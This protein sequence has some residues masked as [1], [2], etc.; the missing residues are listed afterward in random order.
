MPSDLVLGDLIGNDPIKPFELP[1]RCCLEYNLYALPSGRISGEVIGP[2]GKPLRLAVVYLYSASR[3]K[4]RKQGSYSLQGQSRSFAQ[5]KPFEFYHLPGDDYVLVFNPKN[6]E[7]PDAPFPTTFYPHSPSVEGAQVIHLAD[8]QQLSGTDIQVSDALPT[9]RITLRLVWDDRRR[10]DFYPPQVVVNA[11]T[12]ENPFP[13]ETGRDT[14]TLSLLLSS[15]YTIHAEA[16][17]RIGAT[18]KAETSAET[19]DGNDLS[20][21]D[22]TLRF[23]KGECA[24]K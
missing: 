6:E 11:S 16:F 8:G 5:S 3:Y 15:R 7:N 4:E 23:T 1:R 24:H 22:V 19:V 21:S 14:F 9:R 20:V 10:E 17:C 13:E 12:G 18:G 2:D